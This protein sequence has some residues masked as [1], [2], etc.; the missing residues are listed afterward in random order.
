MYLLIYSIDEDYMWYDE[1]DG[2]DQQEGQK[3]LLFVDSLNSSVV[4]ESLFNDI[5]C[6]YG[7]E[8]VVQCLN[9]EYNFITQGMYP[10]DQCYLTIHG[11]YKINSDLSLGI[12]DTP[13]FK[14]FVEQKHK[15]EKE[16]RERKE[17]ESEERLVEKELKELRRLKD[18]YKYYEN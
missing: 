1:S 2:I 18:K 8:T 14:S 17:K 5:R 11:C 6:L 9:S 4:S 12:K 7:E 15:E 10:V 13:E 3:E 16:Y